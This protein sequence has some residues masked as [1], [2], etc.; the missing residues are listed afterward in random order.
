MELGGEFYWGKFAGRWPTGADYAR[1]ASAWAAAI[2]RSFPG[3]RVMAVAGHSVANKDPKD[4]GYLWNQQVYAGLD[5]SAVAGVTLHPYLHLGDA[6]TGTGPLQPGLGPREKGEGPTGWSANATVQQLNLALLRSAGG[7]EALLGVPFFVRSSA[8]G[9]AATHFR[10]PAGLR[11]IVTE[12]NVMERAGPLKLTW[13]HA[14]FTAATAFNL[15]AVPA[16]DSVLL[17]V[18]LNG[19]G[20]GALYETDADF[21]GPFG[22]TPPPGSSATAVGKT[23]C[24]VDD[25][26][27]LV[28]EPYSLTAVGTALGAL[29]LA[30]RGATTATPLD[31]GSGTPRN[32]TRVGVNPAGLPGNVSYPSLLGWRFNGAGHPSNATVLNLSPAVLSFVTPPCAAVATWTT[33]DVSGG[34]PMAWAT[35]TA[36][37]QMAKAPCAGEEAA[38]TLPPY[39][40][41]TV[42]LLLQ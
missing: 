40:I 23:G 42:T 31:L 15:L 36:P 27:A 6:T 39:S 25:C 24:L 14:L 17:H 4:R 13:L 10:L 2:V 11:M 26:V 1:E 18:L 33:P 38:I 35:V 22:G 16:I 19:F 37:V 41:T 20:W 28:T 30:M 29:S 3:T 32:P 21:R 9:N 8:Q 5:T 7:A 34:S 12:Y